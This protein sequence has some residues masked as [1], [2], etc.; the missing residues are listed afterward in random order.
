MESHDALLFS[1]PISKK[2]EWIPI[3][4]KEMER[5]IDF[6]Q[7]SLRRHKLK[8]PCEIE[9]GKNYRDFKKFKDI[10]IIGEPREFLTMPPK[11]I[12]EQFSVVSLPEDTPLTKTIYSH[13]ERKFEV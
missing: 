11:S 8:V 1:I 3:I 4:R 9:V 6:S 10:P 13:M 7:C 2:V 5:P 12:T